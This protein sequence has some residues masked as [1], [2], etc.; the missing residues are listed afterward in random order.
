MCTINTS[1]AKESMEPMFLF[2]SLE[3]GLLYYVC[4]SRGCDA[5]QRHYMQGR[6]MVKYK[7]KGIP[8]LETEKCTRQCCLVSGN[9]NRAQLTRF[10]C[11]FTQAY[12]YASGGRFKGET[13]FGLGN[14]AT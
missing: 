5:S 10:S 12:R 11:G 13:H 9:L 2:L 1:E 3:G 4:Y 6:K 8:K 7:A 14:N